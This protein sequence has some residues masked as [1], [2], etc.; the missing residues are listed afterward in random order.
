MATPDDTSVELTAVP[1]DSV[2]RYVAN[3]AIARLRVID[4]VR[5]PE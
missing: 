3:R 4:D 5:A 2:S 1:D